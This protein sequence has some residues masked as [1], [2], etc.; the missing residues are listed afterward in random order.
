MR[1]YPWTGLSSER[2][3]AHPK[4][5]QKKNEHVRTA[6]GRKVRNFS[7]QVRFTFR[8]GVH[9]VY[10]FAFLSADTWFYPINRG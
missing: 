8:S 3:L 9:F 4:S 7:Q 6:A 10:D 1:V 2:E 5:L